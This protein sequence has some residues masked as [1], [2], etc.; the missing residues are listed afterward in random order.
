MDNTFPKTSSPSSSHDKGGEIYPF[1]P[2][3]RENA[4]EPVYL[5]ASD[6]SEV[7]QWGYIKRDAQ[8]NPVR[9]IG[10]VVVMNDG[11]KHRITMEPAEARRRLQVIDPAPPGTPMKR[12]N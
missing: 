3:T 10:S 4:K 11:T 8:N 7:V 12:T 6:I 1:D 5:A 2:K 9:R